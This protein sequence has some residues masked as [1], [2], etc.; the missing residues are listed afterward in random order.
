MEN[1]DTLVEESEEL[2]KHIQ[3]VNMV[4]DADLPESEVLS[5]HGWYATRKR[6]R[7]EEYRA[8]LTEKLKRTIKKLLGLS[9]EELSPFQVLVSGDGTYV[10]LVWDILTDSEPCEEEKNQLA[11]I[12][13]KKGLTV[14]ESLL[15][16]KYSNKNRFRVRYT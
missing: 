6:A 7:E 1:I 8:D 4:L 9:Y 13:G 14:E 11:N 3:N 12:A 5:L 10:T 15:V 16:L 2:K